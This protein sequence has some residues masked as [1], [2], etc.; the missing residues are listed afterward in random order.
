V[1]VSV[2]RTVRA[3]TVFNLQSLH[4]LCCLILFSHLTHIACTLHFTFLSSLSSLTS[5]TSLSSLSSLTLLT[6]GLL[7]RFTH[8]LP[9]HSTPSLYSLMYHS[10]LTHLFL[11]FHSHRSLHSL[12]SFITLH[13][14][15]IFFF[16]FYLI[17]RRSTCH[18]NSQSQQGRRV[19]PKRAI[20]QVKLKTARMM[21]M[22]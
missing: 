10:S 14:L 13:S 2:Q 6:L 15:T 11:V 4:S 9:L 20:S 21:S 22:L 3:L 1:R 7:A 5:L 17:A 16:S 12:H 8:S 18:Q 19:P